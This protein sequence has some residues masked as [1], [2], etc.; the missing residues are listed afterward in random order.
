[1]AANKPRSIIPAVLVVALLA[2]RRMG[3]GWAKPVLD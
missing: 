3:L 1:M 2:V